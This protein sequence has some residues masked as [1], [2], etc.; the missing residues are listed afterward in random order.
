MADIFDLFKQIAKKEEVSNEPI[1]WLIVG[2]GNPGEKYRLTRHNAGFLTLDYCEQKCHVKA[3]RLRFQSLCTE[4]KIGTHRVLLLKPQT[5][6]NLSGNAVREA[7]S[8]YKIDPAHV[9]VISDDIS[10]PAGRMR[11]RKNGSAG[12]HNG[13]KSIIE[14]LGSDAFPRLKMGVG[15]KPHPDYDL[16]DWVLSEFSKEEQKYLFSAFEC[17]Y[18]G[19]ELILNQKF[20]DAVQLCNSH[21]PATQADQKG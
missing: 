14:Q 4:A 21:R 8:F 11:L 19:I 9:L 17:A 2:L 12:G 5:F 16:A 7:A 20:D 6:M 10:L 1:S 18:H 15:E 13:L 3:D